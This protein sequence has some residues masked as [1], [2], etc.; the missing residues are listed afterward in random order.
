MQELTRGEKWTELG[1]E[2][3]EAFDVTR[4]SAFRRMVEALRKKLSVNFSPEVKDRRD[5][6][7]TLFNL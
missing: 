2:K 4:G 6:L 3:V 7:D 1:E 5:A